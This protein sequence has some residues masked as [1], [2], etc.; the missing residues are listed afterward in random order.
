MMI[1]FPKLP[2][3]FHRNP[4]TIFVSNFIHKFF[5]GL[6]PLTKKEFSFNNKE[7]PSD[8][9]TEDEKFKKVFKDRL[10]LN[11]QISCNQLNGIK[12]EE[13]IKWWYDLRKAAITLDFQSS[14]VRNIHGTFFSTALH[15]QSGITWWPDTGQMI[16]LNNN[17]PDPKAKH[18]DFN[19][20]YRKFLEIEEVCNYFLN[21]G[22][23]LEFKD[24]GNYRFFTPSFYKQVYLG[25]LG[26]EACKAMFKFGEKPL[27]IQQPEE[28]DLCLFEIVDFVVPSLK[29]F[30]DAK[31][32]SEVNMIGLKGGKLSEKIK[33]NASSK[34]QK[35][36]QF[37]PKAKLVIINANSDENGHVTYFNKNFKPI[38]QDIADIIVFPGL[39][40]VKENLKRINIQGY[41]FTQFQQ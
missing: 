18:W 3:F 38:D 36:R 41:I 17:S 24:R 28:I 32:F 20:P 8:I 7:R 13:H 15:K 39:R 33:I 30:V 6:H 25:S 37:Q 29:W 31:Y 19:A 40:Q 23:P 9:I 27:G 1:C 4:I 34:L 22:Y 21:Q 2:F 11:N 10:E 35:V 12:A 16:G 5:A 14:S 26:E